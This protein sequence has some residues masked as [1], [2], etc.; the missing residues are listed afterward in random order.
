[1]VALKRGKELLFVNL[2]WRARQAVNNYARIHYLTPTT[3]R[4]GT[5]RVQS[6]VA[7]TGTWTVRDWIMWDF[8][9]ND[10]GA[11]IPSGGWS[12]LG[13]ENLHQAFAGVTMPI[14]HWPADVPDPALGVHTDGVE[15]LFVGKADFY[16]CE[17]GRYL[18]GMNT[19]SDKTYTLQLDKRAAVHLVTG[20][21]FPPNCVLEIPPMST[22]TLYLH[23][24]A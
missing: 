5:I 19:T 7:S 11:A 6:Q 17:F 22:V 1:V 16:R 10:P 3:E 12:P 13:G 23:Q 15:T 20:K 18:I 14:G 9:I 4:S 8:A 2:Y 21:T 24:D